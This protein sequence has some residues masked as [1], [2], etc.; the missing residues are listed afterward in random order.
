MIEVLYNQNF[1]HRLSGSTRPQ[2]SVSYSMML[3]QHSLHCTTNLAV[4]QP[5]IKLYHPSHYLKLRAIIA[6]IQ[7]STKTCLTKRSSY[8]QKCDHWRDTIRYDVYV[9]SRISMMRR[10]WLINVFLIASA[11][12]CAADGCRMD[13]ASAHAGCGLPQ[14]LSNFQGDNIF[15]YPHI[16]VPTSDDLEPCLACRFVSSR[17]PRS[18]YNVQT[19]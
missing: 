6:L 5:Y 15:K 2:L 12:L 4:Y 9:R 18:S 8:K 11:A 1:D 14:A 10:L 7:P 16:E 19:H 13:P 17:S 3:S